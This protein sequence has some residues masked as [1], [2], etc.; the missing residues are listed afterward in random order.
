MKI[1]IV[2][3]TRTNSER[4][5][6]K[7]FKKINGIPLIE[8]LINRI[9]KVNLP[10]Y[11]AF[12]RE[13]FNDYSYLTKFQNVRL[14]PSKYDND[15]LARM[16]ECANEN[17]LDYVVRITHDKILID[18]DELLNAIKLV[19]EKIIIDYLYS[20]KF[21]DGCG[22]EIISDRALTLAKR[23]FREVEF[24]SYAIKLVAVNQFNYTP[25]ITSKSN[26]RFLIDYT[27]DL[28]LFEYLFSQLGND[29][30]LKAIVEYINN[31][32]YLKVINKL[33]EI[34]IYTCVYNGEKYIE[35]CIK[36]I[37]NQK[38]IDFEYIIVDDFSSDSTFKIITDY[39]LQ[40]SFIKVIRNSEN[41]G[42]A[43]SSNIALNKSEGKYII[44]LDADDMFTSNYAI[45][46]VKSF[47]DETNSEVVYPSN[48][49]GDLDKIQSGM[50][51]H[52]VGGALFYK[53]AL[54]FLKFTDGLRGFEGL[55]LFLRAY[56]KLKVGYYEE[57]IFFYRQHPL[58]L[59]KNNL[60]KR[61]EI[62]KNIL[63]E[64]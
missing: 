7:V 16:E 58:S 42:L 9:S 35:E 41:L 56:D 23:R 64:I 6:R 48:F 60:E 59:S 22:F 2:I 32:R 27:K 5:P 14:H 46:K 38:D 61:E 8:H 24:I 45:K 47:M 50:V 1:G 10:I 28:T 44:R 55:D 49:F 39:A 25:I 15:P 43:S 37:I 53:K 30:G 33:P 17:N 63:N 11:L 62:R 31:S 4:I 52:H 57:P 34:T 12:P 13:Q 36:S 20:T 26:L 29:V 18:P 54:N 51:S 19:E 21:I 40:Y 3:C